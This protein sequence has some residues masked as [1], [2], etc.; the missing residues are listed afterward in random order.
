MKFPEQSQE[1]ALGTE[2]GGVLDVCCQTG[3]FGKTGEGMNI[4]KRNEILVKSFG[5]SNL[6]TIFNTVFL[7]L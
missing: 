5:S 2:V 3:T 7:V 1:K 6:I 4:G